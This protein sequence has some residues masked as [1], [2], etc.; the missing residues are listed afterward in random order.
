MSEQSLTEKFT[1]KITNTIS[2]TITNI[3]KK[4]NLSNKANN[5][6]LLLGISLIIPTAIGLLGYFGY[7]NLIYEN[8]KLQYD[9]QQIYNL[10]Y[11]YSKKLNDRINI[12]EIE[13]KE[14]LE[15]NHILLTTISETPLLNIYKDK[16]I[17][18]CS[19]TISIMMEDSP[20]K[21]TIHIEEEC[22]KQIDLQQDDKIVED[23]ELLNECY[24]SIPLSN[25]KKITG[26]KSFIWFGGN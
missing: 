23:D 3:F 1:E 15:K 2:E 13:L 10:N 4:S 26:I 6:Q 17:S 11:E 5:V 16:P 7:N 20:G 21:P 18:A 22:N 24:D 12:L 19:S 9:M 25:T 8:K 14:Q